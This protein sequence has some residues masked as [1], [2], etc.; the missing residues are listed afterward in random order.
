MGVDSKL[1]A[2]ELPEHHDDPSHRGPD[3]R[4]CTRHCLR[5]HVIHRRRIRRG[6]GPACP[7]RARRFGD[8]HRHGFRAGHQHGV[9]RR[10]RGHR[11]RRATGGRGVRQHGEQTHRLRE[12]RDLQMAKHYPREHQLGG[13]GHCGPERRR[14]AGDRRRE[15]GAHKRGDGPV[16]GNPRPRRPSGPLVAG[17]RS[18][19]RRHPRGRCW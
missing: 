9:V 8:F 11:P 17:R 15:T 12:R 14:P 1:R 5:F 18:R 3:W 16:D 4:R 7:Q 6:R 13:A 2:A 19:P 10:R